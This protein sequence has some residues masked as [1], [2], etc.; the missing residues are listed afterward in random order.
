MAVT[1]SIRPAQ[2]QANP[3]HNVD[4]EGSMKSQGAIDNWWL[5]GEGDSVFFR[6]VEAIQAVENNDT[7]ICIQ[8]TQWAKK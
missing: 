5:L 2:D 6:D 7:P 4:G 3:N 1:A 8:F